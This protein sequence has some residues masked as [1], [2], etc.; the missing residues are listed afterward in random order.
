MK[1]DQLHLRPFFTRAVIFSLFFHL[2]IFSIA[3]DRDIVAGENLFQG[4]CARCHK[5]DADFTGPAL[6]GVT[7]RW[8]SEADLISWIKNSQAMI[9]SG[10][11]RAVQL[12]DEWNQSV[13]PA[14]LTLTDEDVLNI[15]EYVENG[16]T[17]ATDTVAECIDD[18][19]D[20]EESNTVFIILLAVLAGIL[21]LGAVILSRVISGLD[22][23]VRKMQGEDV[24]E[25]EVIP[26]FKKDWFK[27]GMGLVGLIVFCF[28]GYGLYVS[29]ANLGRQQGYAP[30]QPIK[31]SH[32]IHAG[33]LEIDCKYCHV[34][35]ERGKSA[36]IPSAN[37]CMNCHKAVSE[38]PCTDTEEIQKIYDAIGWDGSQYI[39]SATKKPIEWVRIHNLPDHVYFNHAQ[40]VKV[41]GI[42]CQECHGPVEEM[43]V[44]KQYQ[45]LSMGWCVNCHRRT[46]VKF[47]E[48]EYYHETFEELH[49]QFKKN[50]NRIQKDL[51]TEGQLGGTECQK[52]H[53]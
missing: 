53:Y 41:G 31:F 44:V 47:A 20:E 27:K 45:N 17:E 39:D 21:L 37:V 43:S 23:T 32:K 1:I 50:G 7:A 8:E 48:N 13:M 42:E 16:A 6:R 25:G 18:E 11:P 51:I 5:L 22:K 3:Q 30:T 10:H 4:N 28:I 29:A 2:S 36:V 38:G 26:F 9:N 35:A 46:P 24:V 14:F 40:H 34:G 33:M 12:F 52:C 19:E 15:L 49:E